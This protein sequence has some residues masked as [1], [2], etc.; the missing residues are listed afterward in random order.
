VVQLIGSFDQSTRNS[1]KRN[2]GSGTGF[3]PNPLWSLRKTKL[4][5]VSIAETTA[6]AVP[7]FEG[8]ASY[9]RVAAPQPNPRVGVNVL[10]VSILKAAYLFACL[11]HLCALTLSPKPPI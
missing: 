6:R 11:Q 4:Y 9:L 5:L 7:F 8:F 1:R 3:L 10:A 2:A